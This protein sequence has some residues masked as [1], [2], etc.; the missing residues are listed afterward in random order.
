MQNLPYSSP[1]SLHL[2]PSF[3]RQ[4]LFLITPSLEARRL[5]GRRSSIPEGLH[6]VY[7]P[8]VNYGLKT[9]LLQGRFGHW[10]VLSLWQVLLRYD[11]SYYLVTTKIEVLK[12]SYSKGS[13][14]SRFGVFKMFAPNHPRLRLSSDV[15]FANSLIWSAQEQTTSLW[16]KR[17]LSVKNHLHGGISKESISPGIYC[18][19]LNEA[20]PAERAIFRLHLPDRP[21][22]DRD[23][24]ARKRTMTLSLELGHGFARNLYNSQEPQEW[25][26]KKPRALEEPNAELSK[27]R[28]SPVFGENRLLK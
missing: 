8:N 16:V 5:L 14:F 2:P 12:I 21:L 1:T 27:D 25:L 23:T 3:L 24:K 7:W 18:A 15:N 22:D 19:S 20:E 9:R 10:E 6:W 28:S 13:I 17:T 11:R 4:A 26:R